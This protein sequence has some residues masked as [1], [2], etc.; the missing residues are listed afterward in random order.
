MKRP[1][2]LALGH[3]IKGQVYDSFYKDHEI[4]SRYDKDAYAI[5]ELSR[6]QTAEIRQPPFRPGDRSLNVSR[7]GT[8]GLLNK[9]YIRG[10]KKIL[11]PIHNQNFDTRQSLEFL[12]SQARGRGSR[13]RS[14]MTSQ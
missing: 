4:L 9:S 2:K 11:S 6:G 10:S 5:T 14:R 3:N 12:N 13:E 8:S 1:L 7:G